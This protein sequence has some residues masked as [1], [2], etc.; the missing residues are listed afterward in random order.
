MC[1]YVCVFVSVCESVSCVKGMRDLLVVRTG[2]GK[3][4]CV[5]G[6]SVR[7]RSNNE[8]YLRDLLGYEF[9]VPNEN[10]YIPL[11]IKRILPRVIILESNVGHP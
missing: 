8:I 5:A 6:E 1:L 10:T 7:G 3:A 9:G 2:N 4:D 11:L